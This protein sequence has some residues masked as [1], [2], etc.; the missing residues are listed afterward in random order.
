MRLGN[1]ERAVGQETSAVGFKR[2]V[3]PLKLVLGWYSE[4]IKFSHYVFTDG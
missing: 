1:D 3:S 2:A 4:K